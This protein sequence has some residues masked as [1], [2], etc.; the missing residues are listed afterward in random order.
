MKTTLT[1]NI[2]PEDKQALVIAAKQERM[3]LSTY[4]RTKLLKDLKEVSSQ[5][6]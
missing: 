3:S 4:C 5:N 6:E 2:E 1:L